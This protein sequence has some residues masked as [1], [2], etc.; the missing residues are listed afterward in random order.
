MYLGNNAFSKSQKVFFIKANPSYK[1]WLLQ[2]NNVCNTI[3]SLLHY[4]IIIY[5]SHPDEIV[6]RVYDPFPVEF[7]FGKKSYV[8]V[9][10]AFNCNPGN[11][12]E[13][14]NVTVYV[15]GY[16][17]K[18]KGAHNSGM[19]WHPNCHTLLSTT[20]TKTNLDRVYN[21]DGWNS[22]SL[23]ISSS[24]QDNYACLGNLIV[25]IHVEVPDVV[26]NVLSPAAGPE[27]GGT[28]VKAMTSK[29]LPK[30]WSLTCFFDRVSVPATL[31]DDGLIQCV[32]P[33]GPSGVVTFFVCFSVFN[34]TYCS[35]RSPSF[36]YYS[37]TSPSRVVPSHGSIKG[38]MNLTLFG[39]FLKTNDYTC[40][41]AGNVSGNINTSGANCKVYVVKDVQGSYDDDKNTI[42]CTTPMWPE[43]GMVQLSVSLNKQQFSAA[44]PFKYKNWVSTMYKLQWAYVGVGIC[45]AIAIVII[46]VAFI[47]KRH[48]FM[49]PGSGG[50]YLFINSDG[51][52]C[53]TLDE[54]I[55]QE[56]IGRGR[57]SEVHRALWRGSVVAVK[58]LTP[59]RKIDEKFI[60]VFETEVCTMRALRSPS[61]IQFLGSFYSPPDV[62][63]ITE[64][65]E[66]G[67]LFNV[68]HDPEIALPWHTVL[69]MLADAA[70]G[71]HYLHTSKPTV[72]HR[73]LKSLNLL[74]D[75]FWRVKVCD[76]GLSTVCWDGSG[77]GS[78]GLDKV[79][80]DNPQS[81]I[82]T[83]CWTA[84]EVLEGGSF[85]KK[86]DVYSFG[87]ILWECATRCKPYEGVPSFKVIYSVC[88]EN[89]RP[90]VPPDLPP[91]Y[92]RLM[93]SCWDKEPNSRPEFVV[94]LE[95]L[96]DMAR[97][98]WEGQPTTTVDGKTPAK[99]EKL[100]E[101][102]I[103]SLL[104]SDAGIFSNSSSSSSVSQA[105][106]VA[107]ITPKV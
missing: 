85:T 39:N 27:S 82:G 96:D 19:C 15:N 25:G 46:T 42:V 89:E 91:L 107:L 70:R 95:K 36:E 73:D 44:V 67:S 60:R 32:S 93:V 22:F 58:K 56:C 98:N 59:H 99:I 47:Q 52:V 10:G 71:M 106:S 11:D 69:S 66:N 88:T 23:G 5:Q 41:F 17:T 101:V 29:N 49:R 55:F 86:A 21:K 79:C 26:V 45:L 74:V 83:L 3:C 72:L 14:Q 92:T 87:I 4:Y 54:I 2:V 30:N 62:G 64:Y 77:C 100:P 94:V 28:V 97:L 51:A 63:I 80:E 50:E 35:H 90:H 24:A 53:N 68:L 1:I 7:Q 84:P 12:L 33:P 57:F 38:G 16:P 20:L 9:T 81:G 13:Q 37:L 6:F 34:E 40:R 103:L 75:E 76:F 18:K 104:T 65:M 48:T 43:H 102:N 31:L 78:E 8:N 61:I 105:L